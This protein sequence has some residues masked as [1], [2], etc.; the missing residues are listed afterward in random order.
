MF[1]DEPFEA[2]LEALA[3]EL[4]SG[5]LD[6]E[7]VYR[8][9]LRRELDA[10]AGGASRTA[11][12]HVQAA[13]KLE[14]DGEAANEVE[15]VMTVQGPEP[16]EKRSSPIDYEHYLVKQLAPVCDVVLQFL[17]TSFERIAGSQTSLF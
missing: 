1:A 4:A 5:Q 15:Y 7:L 16:I 14:A 17:G 3:K 8:K 11:P 13:R 9:R 12:A 10:Y 6:H 2:W